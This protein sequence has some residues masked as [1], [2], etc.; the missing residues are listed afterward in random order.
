MPELRNRPLRG[1]GATMAPALS[2]MELSRGYQVISDETR[3]AGNPSPAEIVARLHEQMAASSP[4]LAAL[5]AVYDDVR[6]GRREPLTPAQ[7]ARE[8]PALSPAR[9]RKIAV[10]RAARGRG[11]SVQGAAM[12]AGVCTRT[13]RNFEDEWRREQAS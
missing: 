7:I 8:I 11:A 13:G 6:A 4:R 2:R 3:N 9:R 5:V 1:T 10:Y 12:A